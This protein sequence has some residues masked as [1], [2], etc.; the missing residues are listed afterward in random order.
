MKKIHTKIRVLLAQRDL[1][2]EELAKN[3][4]VAYGTINRLSQNKIKGVTFEVLEKLCAYLECDITDI[5]ELK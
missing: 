2:Q 5:L 1:T 3:S 4:G